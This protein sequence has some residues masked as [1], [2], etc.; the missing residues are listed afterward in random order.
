MRTEEQRAADE[1][2]TEAI[3]RCGR[4]YGVIDETA[5][6]QEYVVVI[7]QQQWDVEHDVAIYSYSMLMR[8]GS[9]PGTRIVGL[10]ESAAFDTKRGRPD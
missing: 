9:A 7:G 6:T 8:D 5:M 10:L 4:A 3:E 2:L 1:A